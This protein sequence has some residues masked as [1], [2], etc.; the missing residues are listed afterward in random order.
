M[1]IRLRKLVYLLVLL[2]IVNFSF[3]QE[4]KREIVLGNRTYIEERGL[5]GPLNKHLLFVYDSSGSMEGEKFVRAANFVIAIA[6]QNFDQFELGILAF[7]G[8]N[9]RWGGI[10]DPTSTPPIPKNWAALPS[11]ES[12]DQAYDWIMD[13]GAGGDT[14]VIP[15]LRDAL[16]ENRRYLS[17]ILISDGM[18]HRETT[19]EIV[20]TIE[21]AQSERDNNGLGRASIMIFG[22]NDGYNDTLGQIAV[23]T[24]ASYYYL[25]N[26]NNMGPH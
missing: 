12:V 25:K 7:A 21:T 15:A 4:I 9:Y 18:F 22:A 11:Q 6:E 10:P 8:E 13:L 1:V 3:A 14:I 19:D 20:N 23:D 5:R 26:E 16:Q 24:G 2:L 17:I